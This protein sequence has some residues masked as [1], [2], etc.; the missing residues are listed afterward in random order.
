MTVH[1][2]HSGGD[3]E[4]RAA[5]AGSAGRHF[6]QEQHP[7]RITDGEEGDCSPRTLPGGRGVRHSLAGLVQHCRLR[8]ACPDWANAGVNYAGVKVMC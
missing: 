3:T 4:I 2:S 6:Y 7:V 1:S 8:S 5:K